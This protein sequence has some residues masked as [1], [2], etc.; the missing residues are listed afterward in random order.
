MNTVCNKCSTEPCTC[1]EE[2]HLLIKTKRFSAKTDPCGDSTCDPAQLAAPK[3]EPEYDEI[4]DLATVSNVGES[5]IV[6]VRNSSVYAI[7][8][9]LYMSGYGTY[10][11]V[12]AT[13]D[14]NPTLSLLNDCDGSATAIEGNPNPGTQIPAGTVFYPVPPPYCDENAG[15]PCVEVKGC[16]DAFCADTRE[17]GLGEQVDA[18]RV[19]TGDGAEILKPPSSVGKSIIIGIG[20]KWIIAD[21]ENIVCDIVKN[22]CPDSPV[23]C[24]DAENTVVFTDA[25][26]HFADIPPNTTHIKIEAW[27]GGGGADSA[28]NGAAG[29][30]TV[31][32]WA[33]GKVG[34][35]V[36]AR[37][38]V[39]VAGGGR[40][41]G[42]Q[43]VGTIPGGTP[44][45]GG[46]GVKTFNGGI[47]SGGGGSFVWIGNAPAPPTTNKGNI[48]LVAGGG[49]ASNGHSGGN[50]FPGKAGNNNQDPQAG[51]TGETGVSDH[52]GGGGGYQ[53]GGV[54]HGGLGYVAAD[55]DSKSIEFNPVTINGI[56]LPP[57]NLSPNYVTDRGIGGTDH[58]HSPDTFL[59]GGK[60][61]IA[62][63]FKTICP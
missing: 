58:P 39:M 42:I 50:N 1:F 10:R 54:G 63:T 17:W 31:A 53:G 56:N 2:E 62:I 49:A 7:N 30:Y 33:I 20:G 15:D 35:I 3:Q 57:G 59:A 19:C 25:G 26:T 29:G 8:Q 37:I 55:S 27:G 43:A 44:G 24:V 61:L 21:L 23:N 51:F 48:I 34:I 40:G 22:G 6:T 13:C 32:E 9:W 47:A 52:G 14:R 5:F 38:F 36:G 46:A 60:G 45:W 18:I 12:N 41:V 4:V 11:I 16:E 28:Y